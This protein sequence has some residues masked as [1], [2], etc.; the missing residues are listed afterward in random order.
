MLKTSVRISLA[1]IAAGSLLTVASPALAYDHLI[2][3]Y[4]FIDNAVV[5]T[6]G[7]ACVIDW[8]PGAYSGSTLGAGFFTATISDAQ[9]W[10]PSDVHAHWGMFCPSSPAYYAHIGLGTYFIHI[11]KAVD[12][13]VGDLLVINST[14][15]VAGA[16]SGHTVM[17]TALPTVI[18]PQIK[19][20]IANTTQW[21]LPITDST[22][23]PHGCTDTRYTGVCTPAN[24]QAGAGEGEMR[25]Y[26]DTATGDL[27]GY[28]WSVTSSTTSYF[29]PEVRPYRVGRLNGLNGPAPATE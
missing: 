19:P 2:S 17:I 3:A 5:N 18:S 13:A 9:G 21:R 27:A 16:Y 10:A 11:T 22:T 14:S 7:S 6:T 15:G 4:D 26:T 28:T 23:S 1:S 20:F 12:I 8:T 25:I 29:A 24:F